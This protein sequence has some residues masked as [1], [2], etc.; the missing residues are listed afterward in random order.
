MKLETENGILEGHRECMDYLED[1]VEK[2]FGNAAVLDD[3]AQ[4][5]LLGE[6]ERVFTEE[7]NEMLS[8]VISKEELKKLLWQANVN[9]SPGSDGLTYLVYKECW[10]TLGDALTDVCNCLRD[11]VAKPFTDRVC[12]ETKKTKLDKAKRQAANLSPKL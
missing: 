3:N 12:T 10:D 7:D 4:Q 1:N 9:S 2:V 11:K 8:A 5:T 6:V